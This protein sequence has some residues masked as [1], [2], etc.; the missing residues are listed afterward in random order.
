MDSDTFEK[1]MRSLE[2]FHSLRVLPGAWTV[3][4]VD[5]RSFSRFTESRFEKPFD[6]Q[7]HNLM[8]QTAKAL[9]EE[10]QG[11]YAYTESDEISILLP[12]NWDLFDRSWEKIVSVSASI[13]S[14]TFTHAAQTIVQFDSRVWI[15]ANKSQVVDYFN[16]RQ[17]DAT[18]CALNGWCY[19]TLRKAGESIGKATST[20]EGKSVGFK[21][22][23]LF[24]RGINFNDLP[25]WQRRGTG[26]YWEIYE[27]EGYNPIENK[28]VVT[29]RRRIKV[30]EELPMKE[31]YGEF[32]SRFLDVE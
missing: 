21:N 6:I 11:I 8:V 18:R 16:W 29:K 1:Q 25:A 14:A 12:Q 19:W 32:I 4:R 23:L 17:A 9:L 26:L 24:Q 15:A 13:A 28:A 10:L 22:E 27:K 3:I 7:F 31:A 20:L 30:D 5:G 2:Y